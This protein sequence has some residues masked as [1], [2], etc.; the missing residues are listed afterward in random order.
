MN[1]DTEPG[2][3][4]FEYNNGFYPDVDDTAM[5]LMGLA[6]SGQAWDRRP[7][8]PREESHHA[9]RDGY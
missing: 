9:E 7:H 2:G 6:R 1:P 4:F 3:W 8:A 5:V